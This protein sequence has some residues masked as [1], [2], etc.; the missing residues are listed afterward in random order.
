MKH[1]TW[2]P[3]QPVS[4][5]GVRVSAVVVEHHMQLQL[6]R[7]FGVQ[8]LQKLQKLLVPMPGVTLSNYLALG[9]LKCG[10]E[11]GGAVAF[12]VMGHRSASALF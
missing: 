5:F 11:R 1:E 2:M 9:K 12:I 7:E 6:Y 3:F 4:N 8:A 10:K